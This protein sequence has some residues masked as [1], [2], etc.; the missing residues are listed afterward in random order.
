MTTSTAGIWRHDMAR[1]DLT[2]FEKYLYDDPYVSKQKG[3]RSDTCF[4]C[5]D[6]DFSRMGLPLCRACP[7]CGG[8]IA[9]DDSRCDDCG[10][11]EENGRGPSW[12]IYVCPVCQRS[13]HKSGSKPKNFC[14]GDGR[15]R[16]EG[17]AMEPVVVVPLRD[18]R[19]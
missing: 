8:H 2:P 4:I 17:V 9:A 7:K 6:P 3:P 5:N 11:D 1:E 14:T 12:T 19:A 10:Y 13:W 18:D 16:H 15:G